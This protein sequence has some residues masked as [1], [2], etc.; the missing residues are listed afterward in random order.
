MWP[1]GHK[2]SRVGL[3]PRTRGVSF[4]PKEDPK[5]VVTRVKPVRDDGK[6]S[7][8]IERTVLPLSPFSL[9]SLSTALSVLGISCE[10][11]KSVL[12]YVSESQPILHRVEKVETVQDDIFIFGKKNR[13]SDACCLLFA[14]T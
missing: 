6:R 13:F 7:P 10:Q 8:K 1:P 11:E 4:P 14:D 3:H 2:I 5:N 12:N 9:F